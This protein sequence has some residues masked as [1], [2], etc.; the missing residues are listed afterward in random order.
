MVSPYYD[1]LGFHRDGE[2]WV[3]E[4]AR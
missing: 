1:R 4:L 2:S 3:L